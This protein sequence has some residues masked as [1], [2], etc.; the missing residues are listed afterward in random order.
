MHLILKLLAFLALLYVAAMLGL[1]FGQRKL[2]YVPDPTRVLPETLGL[3]GVEEKIV[4]TADGAQVVT[5]QVKPQPGQKTILYF[6][7]NGGMLAGRAGRVNGFKDAGLGVLLMSY[8][9]YSGSTGSPSESANTGDAR[10][11][12]DTLIA[13]GVQAKDIVVY[14]E[15]L[16][17]GVATRLARDVEVG[18]LILDSPFTSLVDRAAELY[19]FFWVRP[20]I[21]DRYPVAELVADI[22]APLLVMHGSQDRVIPEPMGRA[23]FAAAAEPK[24][25][26]IFPRGNHVDLY[27]R[28]ALNDVV[29]FV[30]GL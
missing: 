11:M 30:K 24:T 2:M 20:F 7:G 15:S 27:E 13:R 14:G 19:P 25:L 26:R 1:F 18:G 23:V 3:S 8:R 10:L 17:T 29:A 21:R 28:G 4:K 9:G 6:H 5:W 22:K 12:Y 16:G